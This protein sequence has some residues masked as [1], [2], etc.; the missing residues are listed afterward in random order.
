VESPARRA[1]EELLVAGSGVA[2][3]VAASRSVVVTV[4]FAE[5]DLHQVVPLAAIA[6]A[7]VPM[8]DSVV[9]PR[10]NAPWKEV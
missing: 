3:A 2:M 4:R 8:A 10:C 7:E 9:V 1:V 5:V 6:A